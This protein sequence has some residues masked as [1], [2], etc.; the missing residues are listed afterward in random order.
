V[1]LRIGTIRS[2]LTESIHEVSVVVAD[3]TGKVIDSDADPDLTF[4]YRSVIKPFQAT[5]SQELGADLGPEQLAIASASHGGHPIH[6]A[7]VTAA[8]AEVGLGPTALRCPPAW[9]SAAVARDLLVAGGQRGPRP[10]YHNCS[11][12]HTGFIRACRAQEWPTADYLNPANPIQ[13]R[14][15]E[16]MHEVTG[17]D[18][19]PDGVDGCGAPTFRGRLPGLATA[20]GRLSIES[21][22]T[23][24]RTAVHRYPALVADNTRE[25]G[26]FA[27][28]WSGPVKA[29]AEGLVAA[30]R[31][32]VGIA[33]KSHDGSLRAAVMGII[34]VSRRLGL[35]PDVALEA[36]TDVSTPPVLGGGVP[37]GAMEPIA[38]GG[39]A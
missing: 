18:P 17:T 12:K 32:G 13:R 24:A 11:G 2:G 8:L 22:F 31:H 26:R 34:E 29:G 1:S 9:P 21:R 6:L 10:L 4:F 27:A 25:D 33:A 28:W 3:A 23:E 30:G 35:L 16:L 38:N 37:V 15:R 5:V 39:P 20:F 14:V 7:F 19:E 36:L